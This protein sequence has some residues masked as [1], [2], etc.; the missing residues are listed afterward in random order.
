MSGEHKL[1]EGDEIV[2]Q[3]C[4][5]FANNRD[6]LLFFTD[7]GNAYKSRVSD[8]EDT[9][10]SL[11][12]D[13]IPSKLEFEADEK[14]LTMVHTADYS[15]TLMAFFAN[16]KCAKVPLSSFITATKRKKLVNSLNTD[17]ELIA[18]FKLDTAPEGLQEREFVLRSAAGKVMIFSSALVL[19][20]A[21]RSTQGV[22]VMR[23]TKTTLESAA[24]FEEGMVRG[25]DG[26]R[27]K[28]I[29]VA[30]TAG[31]VKTLQLTI[32]S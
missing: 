25:A 5:D 3:H 13:Y 24:V 23:L 21:T 27:T 18:M 31:N 30:G 6:E 10:A 32:D 4:A 22:Q 20:K 14:L 28:T 8:F 16:G 17:S 19:P 1:K 26:Y 7:K 15:E 11:I 29:P 12:G 2:A 9:K